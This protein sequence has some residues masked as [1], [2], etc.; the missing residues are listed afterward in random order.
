MKKISILFF[1][2]SLVLF[3]GIITAQNVDLDVPFVPTKY[4]VVDEMLSMAG[5][6][7]DDI[8][9]DLGCGDGR[10]VITAAKKYGT[11]GVGIDIDPK[12]IAESNENAEKENVTDKVQFIRQNLFET[13]FS[14]ATVV[15]MYL[16][17]SVNIELR[18]KLFQ[19]LKPGTRI[20]SHDF[21]MDEWRPDDRS[22]LKGEDF[23]G[24]TVFFWVIPAN[25]TGDWSWTYS[26]GNG[27]RK[28]M[29][30]INQLFQELDGVI[31]SES[32][33]IVPDDIKITGDLLQFGFKESFDGKTVSMYFTGKVNGNSVSGTIE[34]DGI[35]R[36]I[37]WNASRDPE[38]VKMLDV[39]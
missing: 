9:Y 31:K 32:G 17:P 11:R 6:G 26:T 10:I 15:S 25:V 19:T 3:S 37:M 30:K 5:V 34:R 7:E 38:S 39:Y 14:K 35:P 4:V 28:Y 21:D 12:R 2:L 8:L 18:P 24:H 13:D 22:E 27:V 1:T 23:F 33:E 29:L 16:L 36:T 20:V